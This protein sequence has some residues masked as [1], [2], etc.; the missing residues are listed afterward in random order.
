METKYYEIAFNVL[1][2]LYLEPDEVN[3][4]EFIQNFNKIMIDD[5]LTNNFIKELETNLFKL[6]DN[7]G[8]E[9]YIAKNMDILYHNNYFFHNKDLLR[10][11]NGNENMTVREKMIYALFMFLFFIEEYIVGF[12]LQFD[13]DFDKL[14]KRLGYSDYRST[15]IFS[16]FT[17][18]DSVFQLPECFIE[19]DKNDLHPQ[20]GTS[21]TQQTKP[22]TN[23]KT[24][25]KALWKQSKKSLKK[26]HSLLQNDYKFIDE[27]KLDVFISHFD[28]TL[29]PETPKINWIEEQTVFIKL[30]DTIHFCI[31]EKYLYSTNK[32]VYTS[33]LS[34][35]FTINGT[36]TDSKKLR[37]T[38]N[39]IKGIDTKKELEIKNI[40]KKIEKTFSTVD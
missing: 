19:I 22:G 18:D 5:D 11:L 32:T 35:H 33:E 4:E 29:T 38:R 24:K 21:D 36:E 12:C 40:S 34:K 2:Y 25:V 7:K 16:Y 30:F 39:T 27:I 15:D 37:Q 14:Y 31:D 9:G 20:Q 10:S 13:I 17:G 1:N 23:N 6:T 8:R 3:K 26:L 28:G